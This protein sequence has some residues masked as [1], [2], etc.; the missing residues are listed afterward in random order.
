MDCLE[1]LLVSGRRI[2][3]TE[4]A[5]ICQTPHLTQDDKVGLV[6]GETQH[7][8]VRIQAVEAVPC[9]GVPSRAAPLLPDITHD[10]VLALPRTVAV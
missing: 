6:G 10:L 8:E 1:A 5:V 7:D 9:G 2:A 4:T 3:Y